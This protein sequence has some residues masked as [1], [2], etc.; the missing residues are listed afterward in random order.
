MTTMPFNEKELQVLKER[1]CF[2]YMRNVL[3]TPVSPRENM[4]LALAGKPLWMPTTYDYHYMFPL[5]MPDNKAKGNVSDKKLPIEEY[6]G[7]DMFGIVWEYEPNIGGSTV[8]PGNPTLLEVS[9]WREKIVF[10]TKEVIDSWDWAGCYANA[11]VPEEKDFY[12]ELV[13][14][15]GWFERLISFMDFEEAI[16]AIVDPDDKEEV[17]ELFEALADL[18]IMLI[19]KYCEVFPETADAIC[20][21]DDW[22][23]QR[24]QF[25]DREVIMEVFAPSMKRVVDH[26][27]SLGM[28]AE[29]HSCGKVED[30]VPCMIEIGFQ[31]HECQDIMDFDEVVPKYGDKILFHVPQET[32]D[33][34]AP[35][36]VHIDAARAFGDKLLAWGHPVIL[37]DY[38]AKNPVNNI[39]QDEL[40][41]YLRQKM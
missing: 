34:D 8:R 40:Y 7:E 28:D 21:H 2:G 18:Y 24:G 14:C 41:R 16:M 31:M 30:L 12:W 25:F 11:N 32:P 1:F 23:H 29:F 10:P 38:Y 4:R 35:A 37:D 3:D 20:L 26:I 27:H 9:E 36:Q 15:T 13:I 17:K 5:C 6:G 19:G 39:F 22:G 33:Y